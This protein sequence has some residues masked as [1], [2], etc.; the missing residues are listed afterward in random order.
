MVLAGLLL[1][2]VFLARALGGAGAGLDDPD[3]YLPLARSLAAGNGF[4][5]NGRPTAYRPPLYPMVLAPVVLWF[6][7]RAAWGIGALHL[8]LGAATVVL[9]AR[10]GRGWGLSHRRTL[11]AALIVACDPVLVAQS[12]SVMTETLS[13]L[14]TA[15]ALA[16]LTVPNA[17]GGVLGGLAF[18]LGALCR[19]SAL[20][21]MVVTTAAAAVLPPGDRQGRLMLTV[22][23]VVATVIP[24]APWAS[25]NERQLGVPIWTTTHGG[26]TLYL[27]NNPVYYD[28]VLDGPRGAVWTGH[29]QWVWWDSVNRSNQGMPEPEAD[30]HM[31]AEAVRFIASRPHDFARATLARLGRFWGLAPAEAVYPRWLRMATACWTIP[32]WCALAVGLGSRRLWRWPNASAPACVIGL[33]LVH[34]VYWTDLRMR[35]P[36]LPAIA[37]IAASANMMFRGERLMN[38]ITRWAKKPL[39]KKN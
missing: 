32:L 12:R 19:P 24:L 5:L 2:A 35:A 17:M 10:A 20:P 8:A 29:N 6:G 11:I 22:A 37:L 25:R 38:S 28:E 9:T 36:I 15:A 39:R 33:T 3:N 16:G 21:M 18:G 7:D 13:T 1:R 4:S 26:Y 14:L 27:A 31:R 30:R 34:A 23:L